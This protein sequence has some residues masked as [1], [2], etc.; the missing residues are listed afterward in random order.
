MKANGGKIENL[1]PV[2]S[3]ASNLNRPRCTFRP[4][5]SAGGLGISERTF[6][7]SKKNLPSLFS[8]P[9]LVGILGRKI[10]VYAEKVQ[11][12]SNARPMSPSIS[13]IQRRKTGSRSSADAGA[14]PKK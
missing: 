2:T 14:S 9:F 8:L 10:F 12:H 4:L 13:G 6:E 7:F 5:S 3:A 11:L 1:T